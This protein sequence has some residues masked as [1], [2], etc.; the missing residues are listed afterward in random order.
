MLE[1]KRILL[2]TLM[3]FLLLSCTAFAENKKDNYN[4]EYVIT[5]A[6]NIYYVETK[7]VITPSEDTIVFYMSGK[8]IDEGITT[9]TQWA[10]NLKTMQ[11]HV[12]ASMQVDSK[13]GKIINK[14]DA[15]AKWGPI[16]KYSPVYF[17]VKYLY[18][19]HDRLN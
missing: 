15:S 6:P 19:N 17:C 14:N 9:F 10:V 1:T 18:D 12:E 11:G 16:N 2:L 8:N 7:N 4:W 3:T 5:R 13:T